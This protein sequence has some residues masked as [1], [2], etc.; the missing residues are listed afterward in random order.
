MKPV[1]ISKAA[2]FSP[3]PTR[4]TTERPVVQTVP[5]PAYA[6]DRMA[7]ASAASSTT[8]REWLAARLLKSFERLS[9]QANPL[10]KL[11]LLS[12]LAATHTDTAADVIK[13]AYVE[14]LGSLSALYQEA[15]TLR[16]RSLLAIPTTPGVEPLGEAKREAIAAFLAKEYASPTVA[17]NLRQ[18]LGSALAASQTDTATDALIKAYRAT[19]ADRR[20]GI[21]VQMSLCG[22]ARM[23]GFLADEFDRLPEG[24]DRRD[25]MSTLQELLARPLR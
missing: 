25:V 23:A 12:A 6:G 1:Q 5:A 2:P 7:L 10:D 20:T 21:L 11:R 19:S 22:T 17:A 24:E 4:R 13:R 16:F 8:S 3:A 15:L 9:W 14:D 18:V